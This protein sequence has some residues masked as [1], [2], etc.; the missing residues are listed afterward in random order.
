MYQCSSV[1]KTLF[2]F[3]YQPDWIVRYKNGKRSVGSTN[4]VL[5]YHTM[6]AII[7]Y[8]IYKN[9]SLN[10]KNNNNIRILNEYTPSSL[11]QAAWWTCSI[12]SSHGVDRAILL[13]ARNLNEAKEVWSSIRMLNFNKQISFILAIFGSFLGFCMIIYRLFNQIIY[14]YKLHAEHCSMNSDC[15]TD[16]LLINPNFLMKMFGCS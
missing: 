1:E 12:H 15:R 3:I 5:V 10:Q 7:Y 2:F 13:Y 11:K 8:S 9:C 6:I 14:S 4:L 16:A